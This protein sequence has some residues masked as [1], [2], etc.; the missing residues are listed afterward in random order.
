MPT[1]RPLVAAYRLRAIG[2]NIMFYVDALSTSIQACCAGCTYHNMPIHTQNTGS[3]LELST[4]K[5]EVVLYSCVS[6][7][8]AT[9]GKHQTSESDNTVNQH[10]TIQL[11]RPAHPDRESPIPRAVVDLACLPHSG[12]TAFS[13]GHPPTVRP[14][15]RTH[16]GRVAA[17]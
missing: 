17:Q 8:V 7:S 11:H 3:M 16:S 1:M 6:G 4:D 12:K 14:Q 2:D 15:Q 9:C 10:N 5:E 13:G